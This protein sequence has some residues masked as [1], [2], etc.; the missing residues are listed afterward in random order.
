MCL[1]L[2]NSKDSSMPVASSI[3]KVGHIDCEK[4]T[5]E[6]LDATIGNKLNEGLQEVF[7]KHLVAGFTTSGNIAVS[8]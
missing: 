6:I 8:L 2:Q 3:M 4:D 1:L 5:H 7:G